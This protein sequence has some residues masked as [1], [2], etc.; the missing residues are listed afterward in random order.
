VKPIEPS[1]WALFYKLFGNLLAAGYS[2]AESL[3]QLAQAPVSP[4]LQ[5]RLR[6]R[7]ASLSPAASLANCL[8]LKP[9]ALDA[10]TLDL[11][12]K[13]TRVEERVDLLNALSAR[14]SQASWIT[15]LRGDF[16]SWLLIYFA[17]SGGMIFVTFHKVLPMIAQFYEDA[18]RTLPE[19]S[20]LMLTHGRSVLFLLFFLMALLPILRFRP[21]PLRFLIDRL[22][23]IRPW[24]AFTEKI[25]L[26]RFTHM[27]ALLLSKNISP[28]YALI[29][30]ATATENDVIERRL[31]N[32]FN[33]AAASRTLDTA[34]SMATILKS[35]PLVPQTFIGALNIAEKT[36]KLEDT[37]PELAEMSADLLRGYVQTLNNFFY[38]ALTTLVG[39][40]VGWLVLAIYLPVFNLGTLI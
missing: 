4:R 40:L 21:E 39:L 14:Y 2:P 27:L 8:K 25:A 17:I 20:S 24:G 19:P 6:P 11:V 31:Q 26:A 30:A 10:T 23:L 34:P 29:V 18:G 7:L 3:S 16:L 5:E 22:R 37:L 33:D 36:Q 13:S 15:R 32:V 38:A 1:E 12:E 28:R 9:F 35:C